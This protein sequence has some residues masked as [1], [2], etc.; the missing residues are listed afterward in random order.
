MRIVGALVGCVL[1][2]G[3]AAADEAATRTGACL[4]N[5]AARIPTSAGMT[6][7]KADLKHFTGAEMVKIL[8]DGTFAYEINSRE[9]QDAIY[10]FGVSDETAFDDA[11][12]GKNYDLARKI[13]RKNIGEAVVG[14]VTVVIPATVAQLP[15]KFRIICAYNA[16]RTMYISRPTV[17]D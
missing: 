14:A 16:N 1:V 13:F 4:A 11:R 12:S 6:L 2:A 15:V 5:G 17:I 3:A 8:E 9:L 7:G 10:A